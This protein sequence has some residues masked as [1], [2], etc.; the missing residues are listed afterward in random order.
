[1]GSQDLATVS[2]NPEESESVLHIKR[3][4]SVTVQ[5]FPHLV[6]S[7]R[8]LFF[9]SV[10]PIIMS[11]E[12]LLSSISQTHSVGVNQQNFQSFNDLVRLGGFPVTQGIQRISKVQ[13]WGRDRVEGIEV[14]YILKPDPFPQAP[15]VLIHGLKSGHAHP[16]IPINDRQFLVGVYGQRNAANNIGSISFVIFEEDSGRVEVQGP[17]GSPPK[18]GTAYGTFGPIVAFA[19]TEESAFGLCAL[20]MI[21]IDS[22]ANSLL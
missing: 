5:Q 4:C 16:A 18:P 11:S 10:H 2:T 17:F 19:G 13:V 1:M 7:L 22:H 14:T 21:K 9:E 6:L 8:L 15:H 12:P 20:S 3:L